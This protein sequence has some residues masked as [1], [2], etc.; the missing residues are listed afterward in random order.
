[1][2][3]ISFSMTTEAFRNREKTVTRR[4]GWW[5]LR[6]GDLLQGCEKCMGLKKGETIK[7]MHVIRVLRC[8]REPL[9][10][11]VNYGM[12][13]MYREGFPDMTPE[14]FVAMYRA[15]NGGDEMQL[16]NRIEFEYVAEQGATDE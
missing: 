14:E 7:R 13:E 4:S 3:N 9:G 1:M 15:H 16:V 11:I 2:R 12:E 8:T 6:P 5:N 10:C